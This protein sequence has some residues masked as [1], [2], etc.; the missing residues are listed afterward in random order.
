MA[1]L[2][3]NVVWKSS[4]YSLIAQYVPR[5]VGSILDYVDNALM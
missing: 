5:A 3:G 1:M 4:N 2:Y